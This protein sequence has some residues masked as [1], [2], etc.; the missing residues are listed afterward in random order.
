MPNEIPPAGFDPLASGWKRL[1]GRG[2]PETVGEFFTKKKEGGGWRYG[3]LAEPRHANVGGVVHGG[4]LMTFTDDIL[5]MSVWDA[6]GR[7]PVSTIQL[8]TRFIAPARPGD[9]VECE[10]EIQ[11]V[12]KSVVFIRGQLMVGERLVLSADGVWKILGRG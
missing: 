9:F 1:P 3:F 4:M 2:F 7:N 5:G 11:R 6:V 8:N 10:A 12:T